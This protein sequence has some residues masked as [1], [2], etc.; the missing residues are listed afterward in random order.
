[1]IVYTNPNNPTGYV[2]S[3]A[4]LKAIADIAIRHDLIVLE[5][6]CYERIVHDPVFYQTLRFYSLAEQPGM[7]QRTITL[8]GVSKGFHLSGYRIGWIIGASE[9]IQAMQFVQMWSTFSTSPT[10]TEYGVDAALR[11]PLRENYGRA[12]L[13]VYRQNIDCLCETLKEIPEV[14]CARPMDGPFCFMD[15]TNTGYDDRT[16]AHMLY[17]WGVGTTF[18][19]GWGPINGANHIRL[20][21]SNPVD[22]QRK[23]VDRLAQALKDILHNR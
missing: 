16:L 8:G 17:E 11:S 18:G 10:I 19:C 20:A 4:D 14:E 7:R 21:L 13:D 12:S 1:M 15:V 22:Y 2:Y 9:I 6:Q 23:C 5:N 3:Q